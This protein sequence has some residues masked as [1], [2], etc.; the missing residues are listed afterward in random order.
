MPQLPD[1]APV[2]PAPAS[3]TPRAASQN[4]AGQTGPIVITRLDQRR[5]LRLVDSLRAQPGHDANLDVL[6]LELDLATIV[7]P[8]E[9]P[10]TVVTINTRVQLEDV[11][12]GER[13]TV[14]V[15]MPRAAWPAKGRLSVLGPPG[16]ALLGARVGQEVSWP[17]KKGMRRVRLERI[18]YQ[19]EAAS[20]A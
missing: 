7:E 1:L 20:P 3:S 17:E 6:E 19:P 16:M 9:V 14:T 10:P 11:D 4:G 5:L 18:L 12:T 15:V 13:L 2:S 8:R